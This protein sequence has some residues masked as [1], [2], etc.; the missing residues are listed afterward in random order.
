MVCTILFASQNFRVFRVAK[1]IC[2]NLLVTIRSANVSHIAPLKEAK[3]SVTYCCVTIWV[4]GS[5]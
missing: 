5:H 2:E 3:V 1:S 4:A